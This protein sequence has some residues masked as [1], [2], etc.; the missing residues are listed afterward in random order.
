MTISIKNL[1]VALVFVIIAPFQASADEVTDVVN[2]VAA[3]LVQQLPMENKFVLRILTPEETGLPE[4]FL[5]SLAS[6]VEAALLLS[7]QF[8]INMVNRNTTEDLWSEAVEFGDASFE[9]LY[10]ASKADAA[11]ILSP[12]T[13]PDGVELNINVYRLVGNEAGKVLAASGAFLLQVDIKSALGVDLKTVDTDIAA[14]KKQLESLEG[15]TKTIE[16]PKDY[17]EFFHNAN[18]FSKNG[19]VV[20]AV[21]SFIEASRTQPEIIDPLVKIVELIE[22]KFGREAINDLISAKYPDISDRN[23]RIISLLQGFTSLNFM[24]V[25]TLELLD[26]VEIA[27]WVNV[28]IASIA[29]EL[30][31]CQASYLAGTNDWFRLND[32][33]R[34][35]LNDTSFIYELASIEKAKEALRS[36]IETVG[37]SEFFLDGEIERKHIRRD[38][39]LPGP[40]K[41][42]QQLAIANLQVFQRFNRETTRAMS[43]EELFFVFEPLLLTIPYSAKL[44]FT[45]DLLWGENLSFY[46][47]VDMAII[48]QKLGLNL[49]AE[50]ALVLTGKMLDQALNGK[51]KKYRQDQ[52]PNYFICH[53]HTL[54]NL[55]SEFGYASI[56]PGVAKI[57]NF[58]QCSEPPDQSIEYIESWLERANVQ[59]DMFAPEDP[60]G[61][62]DIDI[63]SDMRLGDYS[64]SLDLRSFEEKM[65]AIA[66][67]YAKNH[68][69]AGQHLALTTSMEGSVYEFVWHKGMSIQS[70]F[71]IIGAIYL[72]NSLRH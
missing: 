32:C 21:D 16:G 61:E 40:E 63:R 19:D 18:I 34:V 6:D 49:S 36:Q 64:Q 69:F 53:Y 50:N 20:A 59:Q 33:R 72:E 41:D 62:V 5:R 38:M 2:D 66:R 39:Y 46:R 3:K 26:A 57:L 65:G 14:I 10:S 23:A 31:E 12:R 47:G 8:K 17:A 58:S 56:K 4:S 67:N 55:S 37:F 15:V 68:L 52:I 28:R 13:T 54:N 42:F 9:K 29:S 70:I 43:D 7:S 71:P 27:L 11:I 22:F 48:F 30:S 35:S 51:L 24:D 1:C 44:Q 25:I 60:H 45:E